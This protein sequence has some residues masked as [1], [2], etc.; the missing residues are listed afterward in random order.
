MYVYLYRNIYKC[1]KERKIVFMILR[2]MGF[3]VSIIVEIQ[4]IILTSVFYNLPNQRGDY[5]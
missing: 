4:K 2:S 3:V 1:Y 5:H